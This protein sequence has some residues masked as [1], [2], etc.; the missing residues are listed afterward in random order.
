MEAYSELRCTEGL[1][2]NRLYLNG[3]NLPDAAAAKRWLWIYFW[4]KPVPTGAELLA[5]TR[6]AM[7]KAEAMLRQQEE[8][9]AE[10]RRL[11]DLDDTVPNGSS[12]TPAWPR[13]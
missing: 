7:A 5:E 6:L 11:K 4:R 13:P 1:A 3:M 12:P 9:L 8:T 2:V 10:L